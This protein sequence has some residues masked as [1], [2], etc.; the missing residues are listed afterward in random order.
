[1]TALRIQHRSMAR[2][3]LQCFFVRGVGR[4]QPSRGVILDAEAIDHNR[5]A[6]DFIVG[7]GAPRV[8][9]SPLRADVSPK[10]EELCAAE[11]ERCRPRS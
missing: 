11:G 8:S 6:S 5:K 7:I 4:L 2:R 10:F 1:M 9:Q 3:A